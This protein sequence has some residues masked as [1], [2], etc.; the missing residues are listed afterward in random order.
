MTI[1]EYRNTMISLNKKLF[2]LIF[3]Q[4]SSRSV[5]MMEWDK[6]WAFNK[7]V[8]TLNRINL[9]LVKYFHWYILLD[10]R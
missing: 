10:M 7:K 4:G 2:F 9:H 5:N 6:I 3:P 8:K 1:K